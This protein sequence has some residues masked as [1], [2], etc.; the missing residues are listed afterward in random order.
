[1]RIGSP[2]RF[3]FAPPECRVNDFAAEAMLDFRQVMMRHVKIIVEKHADGCV[4]YPLGL[5]GVV[6]GEGNSYEEALADVQI[7]HPVS[8]RDVWRRSPAGRFAA[9][10]GVR[11]GGHYSRLIAKFPVDAPKSRVMAAFRA[12]GFEV[13][14]E[15]EHIAMR[16]PNHK[17]GSDCLTMPNHSILH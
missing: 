7:R 9:P 4:A 17:G 1:M 6:V 5:K 8:H 14:R 12:P 15:A 16:R 2:V 3:L 11:R 13:V 10:G